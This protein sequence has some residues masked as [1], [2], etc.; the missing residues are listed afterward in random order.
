M[1]QV[2]EANNIHFVLTRVTMDAADFATDLDIQ[3]VT[4]ELGSFWKSAE[5]I[6]LQVEPFMR[7]S[8]IGGDCT[9]DRM[10]TWKGRIIDFMELELR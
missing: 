8:G 3:E 10:S 7:S 5:W 9:P 1:F 4:T 6:W 2:Y